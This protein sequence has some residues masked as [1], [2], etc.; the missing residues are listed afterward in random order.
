MTLF[1]SALA[2][3]A[4]LVPGG[5][6]ARAETLERNAASVVVTPYAPNIVRVTLSTRRADAE[7]PPG[8]GFIARPASAGWRR[9]PSAAGDRLASGRLVVEVAPAPPPAPPSSPQEV[10]FVSSVPDVAL[11]VL[12]PD[13][14]VLLAMTGWEMAPH[15]V[16]GEHTF[17]VAAT[18][19]SPD[20]EH[21]YGLGQNQEGRLDLRGRTLQC[22]HDYDAPAGETVCVPFVVTNRGYGIA[23]DNPSAT[24]FAPGLNGRTQWS[25]EVGERVSFFVIAGSTPDEI[26]AGYRR[27]TGATPLPP[28]AAFGFI[29]SK[30]RYESQQE[31]LDAAEGYRRR[32]YPADV[33]V[34][35]WFYWTRM[36]QFD[37]DPAKWPDPIGMNKR[38]HDEGFQS[39][40]SI[41]PRFRKEGRF[42]DMLA[43]NGWL[44]KNPDGSP[45][46]GLPV[47]SDQ[48][49]ALIDSTNPAARAWYWSAIRDNFMSKGFD[50]FWLDE[51]E[52]DLVPDGSFYS[53]GSGLRFHNLYPLVHT[54]GVHEGMRRDRP[55]Q[56]AL[57]LARAAYL[58]S[59]RNG[60][61][62]WSSDIFPTW[63][64]LKRQVPTGLNFTAS[65]LAYWGNDIGGWQGLPGVHHPARPPLLDP[66]DAREVVGGYDDYPELFT[67]W[68]EYGAFLPTMRVHG[69]RKAVEVWA[70]GKQA[71]PI[72]AKYLRLRYA[73]LPYTYALGRRTYDTGAPFMRALWMD[74][75][76][77]VKTADLGDEYMFGPAFLVA[78]VTDQGVSSR[79]VYLPVGTDW[80][81]WWTGRRFRGGQTI[82]AAAPIDTLPLFVRAGSIVPVG[83]PVQNTTGLQRLAA[84]KVFPGADGDFAL[85]ED[86]G[87][88]YAYEKSGGARTTRLH[89]NDSAGRL[90]VSGD[91]SRAGDPRRV[92]QVVGR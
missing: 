16:M 61:L 5:G 56:R 37:M 55:G 38:L 76:G 22:R 31:V 4:A 44:M 74:F 1:R 68:F 81:D 90:E 13:G 35:D 71:E 86:D 87:R 18:F 6:V 33:M 78:P 60:D 29:Q 19:A 47:R 91:P 77:D 46:Y 73:L 51:T 14:D 9:E 25:S 17:R 83:E 21:Y 85:Y 28:K 50:A 3:A 48:A 54:G 69:T 12:R 72:L 64:A 26:Y 39:I 66:S 32:G 53:I 8:Y 59:Q 84:V 82:T 70:Y 23:W 10:N 43:K 27:L 57:I 75:P 20:D 7:A 62:F 58:G 89:W 65:G 2:L 45:T 49:G 15:D 52:P 36:G 30:Q 80:Y 88:S 63:D 40:I 24:Q 41:W 92:L 34:V 11:K 42:Y 79:P 67:R